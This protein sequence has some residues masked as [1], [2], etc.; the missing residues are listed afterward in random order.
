MSGPAASESSVRPLRA[1][2]I[3]A[4][5]GATDAG[6]KVFTP[7]VK[8][9]T[10][11][12]WLVIRNYSESPS[13]FAGRMGSQVGFDLTGHVRQDKDYGDAPLLALWEQSCLALHRVPLNVD[14]HTLLTGT[15]RL[16]VTYSDPD[17][18]KVMQFVA[19]YEGMTRNT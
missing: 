7:P 11:F 10:P 18:G 12:P 4:L 5:R 8:A 16:L 15:L 13:N 1:A 19:R 3:A 6:N 17:D 9:G 2:A 14:G